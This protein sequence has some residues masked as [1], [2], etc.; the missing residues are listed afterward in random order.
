MNAP[1]KA[2]ISGREP[3]MAFVC[4]DTSVD[5]IQSAAEEMGWR[6]EKVYKGGLRNAVQSLSVSASPA[7]L[8]VDLSECGDPL[9]DISSLA[10]VCEPGTIVIA[11]GQINDVRLYRDLVMSGIHDYILKPCNPDMLRDTFVEASNVLNAPRHDDDSAEKEHV[12]TVVIGTRGGVGASSI[13]SALSWVFSDQ[14]QQTTAHLDLDIHFGTAALA[15]D[16]EPGRGLLDAIENPSRVDSLFLE[17]TM[18][19]ANERLSILSSEASVATPILTDGMAFMQLQNEFR[20]AFQRTVIDMPRNMMINYPHLLK[21]VEVVVV[22]CE[23]TLASARDTIRILSWLKTNASGSR[24]ILLSNKQ[25]AITTEISRKDFESSV[26]AKID[27][28]LPSDPKS[29][30][31]S[32]KLGQTIIAAAPGSKVSEGIKSLADQISQ[33]ADAKKYDGED[34][35]ASKTSKSSLIGKE[36]ISSLKALL[37]KGAKTSKSKKQDA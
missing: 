25:N 17:R 22:V 2:D 23:M 33:I 8:L 26:E 10:E 5:V 29:F 34:T 30:A 6:P 27:L 32:A 21:D 3:F 20:V 7:I 9:N 16:L 36:A 12:S 1:W 15:V 19:K 37:S 31:Q 24:I 4:D 14:R 11:M 35:D 28:I 18:V 13:C